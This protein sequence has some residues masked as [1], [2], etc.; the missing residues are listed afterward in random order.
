LAVSPDERWLT[1]GTQFG[2]YQ[3][4]ADTFERAW[5]TSLKE[6]GITRLAMIHKVI[7][8]A[9]HPGQTSSYSILKQANKWFGW[10]RLDGFPGRRTA[11]DWSAATVVKPS[12]YG[13]PEMALCS[14]SCVEIIVLR[15]QRQFSH[16][17]RG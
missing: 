3:Y 12:E 17:G 10:K 9:Y 7:A 4:H 6:Y 5:F 8:W 15:L 14:K 13:T 11:S 2:V 16:L 1:V